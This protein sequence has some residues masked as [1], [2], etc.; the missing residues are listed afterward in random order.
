MFLS[1]QSLFWK[2]KN[3]Y[4]K[5][6]NLPLKYILSQLPWS[7]VVK[8]PPVNAGDTGLIPGEGTKIPNAM[9]VVRPK[10]EKRSQLSLE[11]SLM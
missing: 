8:N 10:K 6:I 9:C 2:I 3:S 11:G 7:Q 1:P 5:T 4:L